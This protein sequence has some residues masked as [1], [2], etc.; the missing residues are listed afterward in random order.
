MNLPE[1]L[2][3]LQSQMPNVELVAETPEAGDPW[4]AVPPAQLREVCLK[5]RDDPDL[6]FDYLRCLSGVDLGERM[7]T[8]Y[9]LLSLKH[10][11]VLV[12]KVDLDR[13]APEV[14]T[15][16]DIWRTANWFEREA[17]DL[18]GIRFTGHP[19]L[20]RD[21]LDPISHKASTRCSGVDRHRRFDPLGVYH[22][23]RVGQ[24]CR[25]SGT[26]GPAAGPS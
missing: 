5:L 1:I 14:D 19:N 6:A 2:E 22:R 20:T 7:A 8:V 16:Q 18:L 24:G 9:H 11:H 12:L 23:R 10:R 21:R 17:W 4:I 3:Y 26:A 13:D 15:V 25:E